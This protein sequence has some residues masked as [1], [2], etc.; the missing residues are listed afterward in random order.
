MAFSLSGTISG[1]TFNNV[2]G[3]MSQVIQSYVTHDDGR[4]GASPDALTHPTGPH[5][6]GIRPFKGQQ[7]QSTQP[8]PMNG[9]N[10]GYAHQ[11]F[12][13]PSTSSTLLNDASTSRRQDK[14]AGGHS[15]H[16]RSAANTYNTVSGDMN[17]ISVTTY[18]ESGIDILRPFVVVEAL[19]DSG[20]R[21]PEP[22][23]HPG[24]RTAVLEELSTWS[25]HTA[26]ETTILWLHGSAGVGKSAIA[27][28]FAAKCHKDGTLGGSFFFR[29]GH[30]KRGRWNGLITTLAYQLGMAVPEVFFP[31]Q[32]AVERDK[33]ISGRALAVQFQRLLITPFQE[34]SPRIR[35]VVV[36]DGLDECEDHKIQQQILRLFVGA[37]LAHQLPL[38]I[39]ITS[40]PEPHLR[41]VL[42]TQDALAISRQFVL[43]ADRTIYD[44]IRKYFQDEF[45][46]IRS[47]GA[48][49]GTQLGTVW[50]PLEALDQ[51]VA[52]SSGIFV[53]ATTVIRFVDDEYSHPAERLQSLL[54]LDPESTAPLDDLYTVILSALPPIPQNLRIL[55]T[56]WRTTLKPFVDLD[57]EQVDLIL[58]LPQGTS[59]SML[60]ALHSLFYVPPI[61]TAF[62]M[63]YEVKFL[64]ASLADFF[65][66]ARR[67]G[68]WCVALPWLETDQLQGIIRLLSGPPLTHSARV[69]YHSQLRVLSNLLYKTSPSDTLIHALRNN[70]FHDSLFLSVEYFDWPHQKSGY[71]LDLIRLW[72]EHNFVAILCDNARMSRNPKSPPTLKFDSIYA[73]I[74]SQHPDLL[75]ILRTGLVQGLVWFDSTLSLLGWT[76]RI[77]GPLLA[78]RDVLVLPFPEGD[79]PID[80]L[81]DPRR[82]GDLYAK[83]QVIIEELIL[84][85][86]RGSKQFLIAGDFRLYHHWPQLLSRCPPSSRILHELATLDVA[87]LCR[88]MAPNREY[89]RENH[90]LT[91]NP[92]CLQVVLDWLQNFGEPAIVVIKFWERQISDMRQCIESD[93]QRS[94][95]SRGI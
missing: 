25:V 5:T 35:P 57:P 56:I 49:K 85:W 79:S 42:E 12:R 62:S 40:R 24:T 8:Y 55:H 81:A 77:F 63:R 31:L 83:P 67:S 27:Q 38:R 94:N 53:Y 19:H 23:C 46:R 54:N 20:E 66:D 45:S 75:L 61:A 73:E 87:D 3:N 13:S 90:S 7:D 88:E 33:L 6:R 26:P 39:L 52:R 78:F 71:P 28:M 51:L 82:A 21:F 18:G 44:D 59:R 2:S 50:P 93:V 22:A 58:T 65:G 89:H 69:F 15:P 32:H 64:H 4:M 48:T 16:W 14:T 80:F 74:L 76:Y 84:L 9:P 60:R 29:R 36:L 72:D 37:A 11:A 41:Q 95:L 70:K 68:R 17:Q 47:E 34:A 86:L 30:P 43:S 91:L 1:G 10:N 92:L